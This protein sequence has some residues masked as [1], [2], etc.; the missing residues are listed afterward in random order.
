MNHPS[1][2]RRTF[3]TTAGAA[4]T[5][6]LAGCLDGVLSSDESTDPGSSSTQNDGEGSTDA[7]PNSDLPLTGNPGVIHL[8]EQGFESTLRTVGARHQTVTADASGGPVELP[9]VWAWQADDLEPS[10]PG[11]RYVVPEGETFEIHYENTHERPHTIHVHAL[12]KDWADDGAPVGG[13]PRVSPGE[14]LTYTFEADVPGTHFYHCH[15]QT[16]THLD[17][18]MYGFIHVE[19]TDI[20]PADKEYFLTL[21]DWDTQLHESHVRDDVSYDARDRSSDEYTINGRSAPST[22]HPEQGTPLLVESGDTVRLHIGNAGYESHPFHTHGHRFEVIRKDG[23]LIPESQRI[24]QDVVEIAPAQRITIEFEATKDPGIWPAH[25]HKA[26]HVTTG[27]SYP[28][29]MA[30]AIVYEAVMESEAFADVM[31]MAGFDG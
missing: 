23:S 16:D 4:S 25:C 1:P 5:A 31:Q 7:N 6:A 26:H 30:T 21:R 9:E 20:E 15:V 8:E 29:G 13:A 3:L 17:M 10:I 12:T 24:K 28:G 19:P 14:E 2:D 22:F 27:G 18:G 11:P